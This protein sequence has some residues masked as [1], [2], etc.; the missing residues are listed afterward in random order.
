MRLI[1]ETPREAELVRLCRDEQSMVAALVVKSTYDIAR[2]CEPS[3][4]QHRVLTEPQEIAGAP[5]EPE[6]VLGK[7]GVDVLVVGDALAPTDDTR[8]M[9]VGLSVESWVRQVLVLGDRAWRARMWRWEAS[10]PSVFTTM[11]VTWANAFG[12]LARC[13]GV[14]LPHS[15]NPSGKGY[16]VDIDDQL[17]GAP[18]PNIEDIDA[19]LER[20]GQLVE[21]IG[22]A[23]LPSSSSIRI[24]AARDDAKLG[25]VDKSIFNV[26][27]PRHRI[28]AVLGGERVES[29]GWLWG[30]PGP[31]TAV[32]ELPIETFVAE[33]G[34]D[35]RAYE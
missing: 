33:V 7:V 14:E 6:S 1:N 23:P 24:E 28:D 3:R 15:G 10:E 12:G 21:P 34:I 29:W 2:G 30:Q 18:L 11:P 13:N 22:F 8:M 25:G 19:L 17:E 31:S 4:R 32:F 35:G 16:V 26:A 9:A 5:F 27:H 20:P